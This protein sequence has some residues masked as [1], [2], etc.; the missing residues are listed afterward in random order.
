MS[1][2]CC[3]CH[4]PSLYFYIYI[5]FSLS[6]LFKSVGKVMSEGYC[7]SLITAMI[8]SFSLSLRVNGMLSLS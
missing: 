7:L 2:V 3:H 4:S 5:R 6:Q 8:M 1:T